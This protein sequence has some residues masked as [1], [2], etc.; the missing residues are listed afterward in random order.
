LERLTMSRFSINS[1]INDIGVSAQIVGKSNP[2]YNTRGDLSGATYSYTSVTGVIQQLSTEDAEVSE[3]V[4]Q[5]NDI[6]CY[7]DESISISGQL[8]V[9][10][11]I[12]G[13]F[14][15]TTSKNYEIKEVLQE[16]GHYRVLASKL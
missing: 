8:I 12:S 4:M 16:L 14:F 10:N 3:G 6:E 9:T 7:F 2:T 15:G 5:P 11:I 1:I 13:A